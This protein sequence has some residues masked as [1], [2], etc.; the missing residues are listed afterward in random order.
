MNLKDIPPRPKLPP[1][2]PRREE[3]LS[4]ENLAILYVLLVHN[5]PAFV[6]RLINAL[7]EPQHTFI[8]HVDEKYS[9]MQEDLLAYASTIENVFIMEENRLRLNWG[10]YS[11][12]NATLSAMQLALLSERHFDFMVDLSGTH[13]PLKSNKAIRKQLSEKPYAVYMDVGEEPTR[14][15][16]EMWHHYVECDDTIHRITRLP[17]LRGMNIHIGSQWFAIPRHLVE[18]YLYDPLPY[19]Y[20]FYATHIIVA[21]E[22][23]FQT[24]FK[25]SPYCEDLVPKNLL[26]VLFD[27]WENERANETMQERDERKCLSPDPDHC[28]R[29]PT[30]LNLSFKK[31][32]SISKAL[33][34]RKFDPADDGSMALVDL[35]DEWRSNEDIAAVDRGDEG[36][37]FMIRHSGEDGLCWDMLPGDSG[38]IMNKCDPNSMSQWFTMGK[39]GESEHVQTRFII[40]NVT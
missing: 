25:N 1:P 29:S 10:G 37:D 18:W 30:T 7:N 8:V 34:A 22:N 40:Y 14:P 6:K 39:C 11:I 24:L 28:G 20:S 23:Y 27:K 19:D 38:I 3:P 32:L 21:D 31:L 26:F 4:E 33:F 16:A 36:N 2:P 35:I 9:E 5:H 12:V 15:P 13:Y 17:M